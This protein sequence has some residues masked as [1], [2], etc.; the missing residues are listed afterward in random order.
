MTCSMAVAI[1]RNPNLTLDTAL[2]GALRAH[3]WPLHRCCARAAAFE[4]HRHRRHPRLQLF[5]ARRKLL[6]RS[7]LPCSARLPAVY[8]N[9]VVLETISTTLAGSRRWDVHLISCR[10]EQPLVS[11]PY[12]Q[13]LFSE[14]RYQPLNTAVLAAMTSSC[15]ARQD[16]HN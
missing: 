5:G 4:A 2:F 6:S 3:T 10:A 8:N 16:V 14:L 13:S 9:Q 11:V 15:N 1:A 12:T 7:E